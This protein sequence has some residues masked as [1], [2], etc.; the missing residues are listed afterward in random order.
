[1]NRPNHLWFRKPGTHL[2]APRHFIKDGI[3]VD[4]IPPDKLIGEAVVADLSKKPIGA[5]KLPRSSAENS[6][7]KKL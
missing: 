6:K 5:D 2:D 1:V 4:R 3:G 7:E